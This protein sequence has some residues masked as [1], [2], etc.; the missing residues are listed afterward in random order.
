MPGVVE[1]S[2]IQTTTD[3]LGNSSQTAAL[4]TGF[5]IDNKGDILTNQHVIGSSSSINVQFQNGTSVSAKLVGQDPSSDLAVIH[6]NVPASQLH[7]LPLGNAGHG[8]DR[9]AGAGD[10]HPVR[11]HRVGQ[12]RHRVGA[13][14]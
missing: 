7:P 14:A 3:Q 5:V 13:R 11:V 9:P 1:I 4:G 2:T 8:E 12:R 6:V 10:R